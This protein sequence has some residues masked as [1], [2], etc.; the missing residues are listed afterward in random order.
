VDVAG[1]SEYGI[2][3][4]RYQ[5]LMSSPERIASSILADRR[6][7]LEAASLVTRRTYQQKPAR[8][9]YLLTEKSKGLKPV[10]KALIAR[11]GRSA[12]PMLSY[13]LLSSGAK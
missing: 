4:R 10:L 13:S 2:G 7:K 12:I 11:G 5:E 9:E 1:D 3:K 8:Y 6:K